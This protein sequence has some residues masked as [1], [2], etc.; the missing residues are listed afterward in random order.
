MNFG[1]A[2]AVDDALDALNVSLEHLVK[3]VEDH[4]LETID[5]AQLITFMQGFERLR[6][7]LSLVDHQLINEAGRRRLPDTLCQG[8]LP[9][10]L[11]ATLRV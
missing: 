10:L 6:N 5:D 3:L 7:Q 1:D 11:A 4:R 8:S 2:N 9:R